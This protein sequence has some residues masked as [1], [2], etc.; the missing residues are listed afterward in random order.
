[1]S[2]FYW[3]YENNKKQKPVDKTTVAYAYSLADEGYD[4]AKR[5]GVIW[6]GVKVS[7]YKYNTMYY[8]TG[9]SSRLCGINKNRLKLLLDMG[10]MIHL[11]KK[12][13]R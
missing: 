7:F 4:Y 8:Y 2:A 13:R 12:Y 9:S 1:M 3:R 5:N 11:K 6:K 10:E